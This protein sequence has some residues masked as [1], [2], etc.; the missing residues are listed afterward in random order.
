MHAT[1]TPIA[2]E[3]PAWST[4]SLHPPGSLRLQWSIIVQGIILNAFCLAA[5]FTFSWDALLVTLVLWLLTA[6][7]GISLGYHRLLSHASFKTSPLFK[8]TLTV[9]GMLANQGPPLVW[10][11]THRLHHRYPDRPGDPHSPR[12]S[13]WWAHF[14]WVFLFPHDQ[15]RRAARDLAR[16]RGLVLLDRCYFLPQLILIALL[17]LA[18]GWPWVVWGFFVRMSF[19]LT[20]TSLVNSAAHRWGYRNFET[21]DNSRNNWWVAAVTFGEGWHNN[22]HADPRLAAHGLRWWEVD[23]TYLVIR[24]LLALGLIHDVKQSRAAARHR[25][26]FAYAKL[27]VRR[28]PLFAALQYFLDSGDLLDPKETWK[29]WTEPAHPWFEAAARAWPPLGQRRAFL[30]RMLRRDHADGIAAHYDIAPAFYRLWLDR[31]YMFYSC[32]KFDSPADSLEQAQKNKAGF[33]LDLLQPRPGERILD[34]GCGWGG[35]MKA[36]LAQTN[37][38]D[39]LLGL[40]LSQAQVAYVAEVLGLPCAYANFVSKDYPRGCC[41]KLCTVGSL[42]HVRPHE[43]ETLHHKLFQALPRGGRVVHQFF[44]ADANP[45][46]TYMVALQHFFPGTVLSRHDRISAAIR[47]AGFRIAVDATDDYRPTL[48]AWFDNLAA[49]LQAAVGLVGV[50]VCNKYLVF[51]PASWRFFADGQAR[52]HRLLLLKE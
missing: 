12:N 22:H 26:L 9:L 40:S 19:M 44:S 45:L 8:Y 24:M 3:A 10:V 48:R 33:L 14:F 32:A 17:Y 42:E 18:G 25:T 4:R 49:N 28:G 1:S 50:E 20:F 51:L 21:H 29:F 47:R 46:S 41:D 11:G 34:L 15:A 5:P 38:K 31:E 37:E 23:L 27:S 16:D 43:I 6:C 2:L 52:L 30:D 39:R 13:F 7:L 35:M 36:I